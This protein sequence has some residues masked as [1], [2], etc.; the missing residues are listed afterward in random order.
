MYQVTEY[1]DA[2]CIVRV[3]RPILTDME[4]KVWEE[5]VKKAL[6]RFEK[7]RIKHNGYKN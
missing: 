4:R 6:V 1:R 5:E 3:H 7:E 2:K